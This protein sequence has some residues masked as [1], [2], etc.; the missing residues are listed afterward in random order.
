M[1]RN[2]FLLAAF[3]PEPDELALAH[4]KVILRG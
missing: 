2:F 1:D 4:L 3:L